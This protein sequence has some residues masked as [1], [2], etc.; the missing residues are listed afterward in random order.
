MLLLEPVSDRVRPVCSG[1][2]SDGA[3][4]LLS[5]DFEGA[6][7]RLTLDLVLRTRLNNVGSVVDSANHH[8]VVE[9]LVLVVDIICQVLHLLIRVVGVAIHVVNLHV[10]RGF[11]NDCEL[12]RTHQVFG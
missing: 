3:S 2:F 7:S 1:A 6:F 8:Q 11:T 10:F 5:Q 12:D 9:V 4:N